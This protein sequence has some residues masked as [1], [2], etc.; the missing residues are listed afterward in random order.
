[1]GNIRSSS[2]ITHTHTHT[3]IYIYIVYGECEC[4]A[5][6]KHL[7]NA[8]VDSNS[9]TSLGSCLDPCS[10]KIFPLYLGLVRHSY[11]HNR[12]LSLP[13]PDRVE[14]GGSLKPRPAPQQFHFRTSFETGLSLTICGHQPWHVATVW[15]MVAHSHLGHDVDPISY[16]SMLAHTRTHGRP[17]STSPVDPALTYLTQNVTCGPLGLV[18]THACQVDIFDR[19]IETYRYMC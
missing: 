6:R 9:R 2:I 19:S 7:S 13:E 1:M 18:S 4:G 5:R 11:F 16:D 15:I 17:S 10:S 14:H 8:V 12:P 3:H